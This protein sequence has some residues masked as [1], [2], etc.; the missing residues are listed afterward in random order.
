MPTFLEVYYCVYTIKNFISV[1]LKQ[2]LGKHE[3]KHGLGRRDRQTD[4]QKDIQTD[5]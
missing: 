1:K 2:N 5:S 4:K 3:R